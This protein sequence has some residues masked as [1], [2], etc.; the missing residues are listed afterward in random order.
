MYGGSGKHGRGGGGGRG[1]RNISS[2]YHAPP[3]QRSSAAS[4]GRLSVGSGAAGPRGCSTSSTPNSSAASNEV[5]ES[6]SLA[7]GNALNFSMIIRLAPGLVEEIKRVEADGGLAQIKFDANANNSTGNVIKVGNKD[8]RFTWSRDGGDLCDIYEQRQSGDEGN[9]LLVE[10]GSA[11]RKLNV[12]RVLD[13]SAKN[14]VK[15]LSEEAERKS[16][17]RKAIVLDHGNPSTKSQMKAMAAVEGNQ[18]RAGFKQPPFKKRKTEPPPCG[19]S[20]PA[21][22]SVGLS[23]LTPSQGRPSTSPLSSPIHGFGSGLKQSQTTIGDDVPSQP[24]NKSTSSVNEI[25]QS[26]AIQNMLACKRSI[27]TKPSDLRSLLIIALTENQSNGLSLK[28]L[29]KAAGNAFPNSVRQI[30]PILKKIATFQAPGRYFLKPG[31]EMENINTSIVESGSSPEDHFYT[32][33]ALNKHDELPASQP[34]FSMRNAT[35][36]L[37]HQAQLDSKTEETHNPFEEVNILE[38]SPDCSVQEKA[39]DHSL[40]VAESSSD[41]GSDNDS[42]SDSSDSGSQSRSPHGSRSMSRTSSDSESGASSKS[43]EA[44]DVEVDIMSDDDGGEK[45]QGQAPEHWLAKSPIQSGGTQDIEPGQVAGTYAKEEYVPVLDNGDINK[46]FQDRGIEESNITDKAHVKEGKEAEMTELSSDQHETLG[47]QVPTA[48]FYSEKEKMSKKGIKHELS[49]SI[50]RTPKTKSERL[51]DVKQFDDIHDHTK[52]LKTGN[53]NHQQSSV[54][55]S[56]FSEGVSQ[57]SSSDRLLESSSQRHGEFTG[58]GKAVLAS[59]RPGKYGNTLSCSAKCSESSFLVNGGFPSQ[60]ENLS[61]GPLYQDGLLDEQKTMKNSKDNTMDWNQTAVDSLFIKHDNL[62][63][64]CSPTEKNTSN[65]GRSSINGKNKKLQRELSDLELGEF[66]DFTPEDAPT[67]KRQ[68]ERRSSVKGENN[69]SSDHWTLEACKGKGTVKVF[70]G[71]KKTSPPHTS[72]TGGTPDGLSK[73]KSLGPYPEDCRRLQSKSQQPHSQQSHPR[74]DQNEVGQLNRSLEVSGR[75]R[76]SEVAGTPEAYGDNHKKFPA[77]AAQMHEGKWGSGPISTKESNTQ[78]SNLATDINGRRKD[79]SLTGSNEDQKRKASPSDEISCSYLKYEKQGPELKG[80]IKDF[81]QYQEYVQEYLEKY[82]SY[83]SLNKSL[84]S[85]RIKFSKLGKDL[86]ASK[87]RDMERYYD[88]LE[89]LKESYRQCGARHKRLKKI[90]VV[91]HEELKHLKQ[92]MTEFAA[93]CAKS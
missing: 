12:Q 80:P 25:P 54:R 67:M 86:G 84:E 57:H 88:I 11:W 71:S 5:E 72:I 78:N 44:S 32:P 22:K 90:F 73:R 89:Q 35:N 74:V 53:V 38:E 34:N 62:D 31:V 6:F 33:P 83:C 56:V 13:E 37:E 51:S 77:N 23:T 41:S 82:E 47:G 16:K 19:P 7:T 60:R 15:M 46:L 4:G 24:V 45:H 69:P 8:F 58:Q 59:E 50:F 92:M 36:E 63:P 18:W 48:I 26:Y 49:N 75:N 55:N 81:P 52:R 3:V 42:E 20:K 10:S 87:G 66:R 40:G 21:Y 1:K 28:A 14:H 27:D 61:K 85:D 43:K 70:S 65:F 93:S 76:Q 39:S 17:S 29:E 68:T 64:G 9:G 30:E 91:L 2:S 79:A